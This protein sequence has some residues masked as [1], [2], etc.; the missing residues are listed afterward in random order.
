M[1]NRSPR[2]L[3]VEDE[4]LVAADVGSA[5]AAERWE[6]LGPVPDVPLALKVLA[7]SRP[8]AVCLDMNLKGGSSV[9]LAQQLMDQGI[10]FVILTGDT[11]H[12]SHHPV[13]KGAPVVQKPYCTRTLVSTIAEVLRGSAGRGYAPQATACAGN[14]PR[15]TP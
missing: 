4:Y 11:G 10:P 15:A 14:R 8:D 13:F 7:V 5:L 1:A 2:I 9:A 6:V 12:L 3:V